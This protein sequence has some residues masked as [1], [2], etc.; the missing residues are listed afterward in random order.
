M[1]IENDNPVRLQTSGEL[2]YECYCHIDLSNGAYTEWLIQDQ[3]RNET[4]LVDCLINNGTLEGPGCFIPEYVPDVFFFSILMMIC[5]FMLSV[6]L[7]QCKTTP[8]FQSKYR[9]SISDFAVPIAIFLV[10]FIDFLV[11]LQTPKLIVPDRFEVCLQHICICTVK[12]KLFFIAY[13][14]TP[15]MDC[16]FFS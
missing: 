3:R 11:G 9:Q 16:S 14:A 4:A 6:F 15:W 13:F 7:K 12:L 8:Y 2:S 1:K 5:T 10:T